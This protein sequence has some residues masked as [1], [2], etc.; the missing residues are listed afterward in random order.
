MDEIEVKL[1]SSDMVEKQ[2][3][4]WI[5]TKEFL[6]GFPLPSERDLAAQLGVGRPAIRE[7]LQRLER[8]GWISMR[9]GQPALINDFWQHGNLNTL[10]NVVQYAND[11]PSDFIT[12][13]LDFRIIL[14]PAYVRSAVERTPAKVVALLAQIDEIEDTP[15]GYA[16]FDWNL[17]KG[18]ALLAENPIYL[19]V[20]NSFDQIF[21]PLS[22]EYF[23]HSEN[24]QISLKFYQQLL[25]AAMA[26]DA[27]LACTVTREAMA[28]S[29]SRW[30]HQDND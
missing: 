20:L 28:K 12:H 18:L 9:K 25:F 5:I 22:I 17:Q 29:K 21:I 23:S 26:S 24:R 6:A 14:T 10:V 2:L 3:V 4:Q 16:S 27:D 7:A 30:I 8:D 11:L 19:L 1:R 13:L 15:G